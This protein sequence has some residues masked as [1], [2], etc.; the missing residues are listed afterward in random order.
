M[1]LSAR[2]FAQRQQVAREVFCDSFSPEQWERVEVAMHKGLFHCTCGVATYGDM[3]RMRAI[4]LY[5][6]AADTVVATRDGR[7]VQ[8]CDADTRALACH[9]RGGER[10]SGVMLP[11]DAPV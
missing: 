6:D 3:A 2:D 9:L 1:S 5:V 8:G 11:I 4:T 7:S 10:G